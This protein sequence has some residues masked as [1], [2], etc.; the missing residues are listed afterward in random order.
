MR[1]ILTV[2]FHVYGVI[3]SVKWKCWGRVVLILVFCKESM[4]LGVALELVE[5][6][7]KAKNLM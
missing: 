1:D 7:Q 6:V 5:L 4:Y 2:S 3:L